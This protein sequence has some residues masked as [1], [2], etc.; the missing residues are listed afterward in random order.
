MLFLVHINIMAGLKMD[1][2]PVVETYCQKLSKE[3]CI[4]LNRYY[5][6]MSLLGGQGRWKESG[7]GVTDSTPLPEPPVACRS[8]SLTINSNNVQAIRDARG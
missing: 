1:V 8:G 4:G 2:I 6:T 5:Q 3:A 7:A